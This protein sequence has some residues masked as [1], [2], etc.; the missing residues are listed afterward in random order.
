MN[1]KDLVNYESHVSNSNNYGTFET[2]ESVESFP[3]L[4]GNGVFVAYKQIN[5]A[6]DFLKEPDLA[7]QNTP[8]NTEQV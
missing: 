7:K 5:Y 6:S 4:V 8:N 1:K 2:S 3:R